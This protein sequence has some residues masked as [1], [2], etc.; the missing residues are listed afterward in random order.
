MEQ[1]LL[2]C[3]LPKETFTAIMM[4]YGSTG[5]LT[6]WWHRLCWHCRCS[7]ASRYMSTKFVYNPPRLCT[8]NLNESNKR[9]RFPILKRQEADNIRQKVWQTQYTHDRALLAKTP[10]QAKSWLHCLKPTVRA[11]GLY[12]NANKLQFMFQTIW[13]YLHFK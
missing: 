12:V 5:S 8:T 11:I 2:A 6:W 10:A 13:S 9:K 3:G 4:L 7:F 1:I